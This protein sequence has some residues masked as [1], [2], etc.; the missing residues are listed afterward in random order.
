VKP[1]FYRVAAIVILAA[2]FSLATG[3]ELSLHD[4][5]ERVIYGKSESIDILIIAMLAGGCVLLEDVPGAGKTTLAKALA[6]STNAE[7]R[8]IQFTPDLLPADIL[9]SSIYNPVTGSF[10]FRR[11]PIFCNILLLV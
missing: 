8:R 10:D 6:R 9:G 2:F 4:N 5:L 7:F 1:L 3:L 11:G